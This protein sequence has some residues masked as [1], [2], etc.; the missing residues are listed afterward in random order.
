VRS[1]EHVR[2]GNS[3]RRALSSKYFEA[4]ITFSFAS[5]LVALALE[6]KAY[7]KL[8]K[9]NSD[10]ISLSKRLPPVASRPRS[11][12]REQAGQRLPQTRSEGNKKQ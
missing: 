10:Q 1:E 8:D 6:D 12:D 2:W 4:P 9:E 5:A 3:A 7:T 11:R